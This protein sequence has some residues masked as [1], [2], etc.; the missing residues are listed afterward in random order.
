MIQNPILPGF[1]PD[2]CI[3]RVGDDYYIATSTF[4]WWPGVRIHHSRDLKHWRLVGHALDRPSQMDLAGVPDSGG[5]WAP[6]LTHADGVFWLIY[7][8]VRHFRNGFKDAPNYLVTAERIEGPWSDPVFLN[9]SGFDPSLF[10]NRDGRK[11]LVNQLWNHQPAH[12]RFAGIVLQEYDPRRR[13]LVGPI[14]N[15]FRGSTLGFTEGPHLY[16]RGDFYYLLTAEGGTGVNHAVTLARSRDIEGAYELSPNHPVL[17]SRDRPHLRLQKAGHA[18][19]VETQGGDWYLVHLCGRWVSDTNRVCILGR[20]TAIQRVNWTAEG[21]L[22]LTQGGNEPHAAIPEPALPAHPWPAV[23]AR[24]DFDSEAL[25]SRFQ[26]LRAPFDPRCGSLTERPGWLRLYGRMSPVNLFE[27]SVVAQRVTG[28][29]AEA[30]CVME[31]APEDFQ[32]MAGLMAIYDTTKWYYLRVTRLDR[33]LVV[34]VTWND[35]GKYGEG[36][37]DIELPERVP[38]RLKG[39]IDGERLVFKYAAGTDDWQDIQGVFDALRLSDEYGQGGFTGAFFAMACHDI[40]GRRMPAD[41]DWFEYRDL[42]SGH[43]HGSTL[44]VGASPVR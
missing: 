39:V 17:T 31:F 41:F 26:S 8:V 28:F 34:G 7:T 2:P 9:S 44:R 30:S 3:C 36:G 27:Q 15:I 5:I 37:G 38:L 32:Q 6:C 42:E 10:H 12:H 18:S 40:S 23:A 20:E 19:L 33:R 11:W 13:K 35:N 24:D 21:W 25:D 29:Q 43:G 16:R 4:E 1:H 14:R 22:E